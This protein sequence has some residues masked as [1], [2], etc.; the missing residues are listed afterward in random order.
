M[1]FGEPLDDS[2]FLAAIRLAYDSGIRTF[3]TSDVYGNGAADEMLGRGLAGI[4]RSSYCLV[5]ILGHDFYTGSREGS[6]GYPRFTD[7]RLRKP[8]DY[9]GY[10]R[11]ATEKMLERTQ[12][13]HF[14]CLMLHNPDSTGF[15]SDAVWNGLEQI[16]SEKMTD[17]LG[18]APGPANGFSL[19]LI[20][21]FERFGPL[22]DWAMIILS[23]MEPWPGSLCIP[24]AE[25]FNVK[26]LTR[27][28]DHG[29]IFHDD[30]KPGHQFAKYDHR[31]FRPAGW[32]EAGN[33]KLDR[34]R[35]I[36]QRHGL[37]ALQLASL[38]NLSHPQVLSVAP[39][40][41]QE[42]GPNA[43]SIESKIAELA[44]L[45]HLTLSKEEALEIEQIGN[46]TGCMELKGGSPS[47][48]GE[49]APDRWPLTPELEQVAQ[50]WN[51]VP[52]K[53]LACT[54]SH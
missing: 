19:D 16:R 24:A 5:G 30:V 10:L 15:T 18:I 48:A 8:S 49:P 36:A 45:P 39:T 40:M 41:M 6:K 11:M 7:P 23:P 34:M 50:R 26:L 17:L 25:K 4:P 1:H 33:Q 47:Y 52:S 12:T 29:G 9:P 27:V 37:S 20:L 21:S 28:V 46:N 13:D 43:K 54:H 38:W 44:A 22:I 2:R 51:I 31:T 3:I 14:D 53:D 42:S 35:A 32:V